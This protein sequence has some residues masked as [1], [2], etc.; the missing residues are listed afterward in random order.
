MSFSEYFKKKGLTAII[1]MYFS[2]GLHNLLGAYAIERLDSVE[3]V[4][5][6]WAVVDI[7]PASQHSRRLYTGFGLSGYILHH[8]PVPSRRWENGRLVELPPRAEPEMFT[9][10]G[11]IGTTEVSGL[12][13]D[14][15]YD[16]AK[17][18]P[19]IPVITFKEALGVEMDRDCKLLVDLGFN[20]TEPIDINGQKVSP[21][22]V[23]EHLAMNQPA[24]TMKG[25]DIRWGGCAIVQGTKDGRK[26]EYRVE[27]WPSEDLAQHHRDMDC[28]RFGG[29]GGIFRSGSPMGSV[30]VLIA[31]DQIDYR[32]VYLPEFTVP[33]ETFLKQEVAMGMNVEVTK[34]V[35]W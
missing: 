24:E 10:K 3:R 29:P 12:P 14:S 26:T 30:A 32:G 25:P 23:L 16:L 4:D 2:P 21:W 28:A 17:L 20:Q 9:F 5:F 6:R 34:N 19:E 31:R 11:P 1:D 33:S 27:A 22:A 15:M 8:Y 7:V 13:G 18:R 35:A